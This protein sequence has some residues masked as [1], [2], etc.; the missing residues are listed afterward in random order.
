[1]SNFLNDLDYFAQKMGDL[2]DR[3]GLAL[4]P[5]MVENY[6]RI[7]SRELT[8]EMFERAWE[9]LYASYD[10]YGMPTPRQFIEAAVGTAEQRAIAEWDALTRLADS[11]EPCTITTTASQA[12]KHIGGTAG[13]RNSAPKDRSFLRRDFIQVYSAKCEL[14]EFDGHPVELGQYVPVDFPNQIAGSSQRALPPGP[15]ELA[16]Q[17]KLAQLMANVGGSRPSRDGASVPSGSSGL[18]PRERYEVV[19]QQFAPD[20]LQ[21]DPILRK[22]QNAQASARIK[23]IAPDA[24]AGLMAEMELFLASLETEGDGTK[25]EEDLVLFEVKRDKWM[26]L[27]GLPGFAQESAAIWKFLQMMADGVGFHPDAAALADEFIESIESEAKD[28]SIDDDLAQSLALQMEE[29]EAA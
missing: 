2:C 9:R 1:M 13:I 26:A 11:R 7:L 17:R 21:V 23:A 8:G 10:G 24:D 27:R 15:E 19:R 28:L 22:E 14:G 20:R 25:R 4:K 18:S 29:L 5:S 3:M 16:N 12:L 6:H